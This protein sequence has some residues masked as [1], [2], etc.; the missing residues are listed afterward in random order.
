M[1]VGIARV[2][3]EIGKDPARCILVDRL[4]PRGLARS[5]APFDAWAKDVAPS[6]ELRKWYGHVPERFE[7]FAH[8]YRDELANSPAR[9]ALEELSLRV[10]ETDM[11]LLTATKDLERSGAA[12]LKGV[13]DGLESVP[14][15]DAGHRPQ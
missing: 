3:D 2:Y 14:N 4:W 5:K 1:T 6:A 15:N 13:L 11:L 12:V 9:Q 8:R 7:E 10:S